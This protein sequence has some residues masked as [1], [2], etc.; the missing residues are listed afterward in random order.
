M[1]KN[2]TVKCERIKLIYMSVI[3]YTIEY[4]SQR[5]GGGEYR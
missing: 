3:Y 5:G 4:D 2:I 1:P